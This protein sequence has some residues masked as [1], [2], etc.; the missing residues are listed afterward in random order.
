MAGNS[1]ATNPSFPEAA[2]LLAGPH[3]LWECNGQDRYPVFKKALALFRSRYC[4]HL[5]E[6]SLLS[7]MDVKQGLITSQ[8][9]A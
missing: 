4:R 8:G 1:T 2:S 3:L 5:L 9:P 7:A 6:K